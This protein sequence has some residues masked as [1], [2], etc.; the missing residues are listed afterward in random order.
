M[1]FKHMTVGRKLI[2]LGILGTSI[3]LMITAGIALK[4]GAAA[5]KIGTTESQ[6]LS[7]ESQRHILEGVIA[8]VTS[9]QDVLEQ[10]TI[11]DLNV[12][13]EALVVAGGMAFGQDKTS[14]KAR[15][16]TTAVEQTV[17]LPQAQIGARGVVPNPDMKTMSPV[18]DKV[19]SLVGGKCTIFQR[20]N[21]AGD[22]LRIL[23]NVETKDGQR[24]IGTYIP[25][26]NSDGGLNPVI[27]NVLRG[28]RYVGRAFVVNAWYVTAYEPICN[29]AGKVVGMLFTGVP[30][31]SAK[32]L[33][34][35][36]TKSRQVDEL[37]TE[38]A[39]VSREQSQ[40]IEQVNTA[41][42]QMDKVTQ[43]NAANAQESASAAEELNAQADALRG[44]VGGLLQ[45]VGGQAYAAAGA[46]PLRLQNAATL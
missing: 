33:A 38:V 22:M 42:S 25:S 14:W 46:N 9:Q 20:M 36:V 39:A 45:L 15:N 34:E 44:V 18:V 31:E 11:G 12:A 13:R 23:T 27:R 8:M 6:K 1:N 28:E 37:A 4:Q 41:V 19:K 35:I 7:A 5:E 24:A 16:Q 32:S 29:P 2:T 17:E 21:E 43:S 10:K 26:V 3:P 40:G 30:E